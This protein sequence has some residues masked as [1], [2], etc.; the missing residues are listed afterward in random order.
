MMMSLN[1]LRVLPD[2]LLLLLTLTVSS[3]YAQQGQ[4]P[5]APT[6]NTGNLI[7]RLY[8]VE[9][10]GNRLERAVDQHPLIQQYGQER[11]YMQ[12]IL[13]EVRASALGRYGQSIS[14]A[15]EQLST[16][17]IDSLLVL[18]ESDKGELV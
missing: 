4:Q 6:D 13:E 11:L 14:E 18:L 8:T 10:F 3:L 9:D 7:D 12:S 1:I 15:Y 2:K 17:E 16:Q 5:V